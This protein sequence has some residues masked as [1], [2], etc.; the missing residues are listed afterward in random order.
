MFKDVELSREEMSSYKSRL[1]EMAADEPSTANKL[2]LSVSIL[3]AAAWPTY[4]TVPV[5]IPS[6]IQA[7]VDRF[8]LHYK[9]KHS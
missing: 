3:S 4:P 2:D 6:N 9:S 5:I 8:E 7:A 1:D